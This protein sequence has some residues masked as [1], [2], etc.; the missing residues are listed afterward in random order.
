KMTWS[1]EAESLR[2]EIFDKE[3]LPA[4][5]GR[6]EN[7]G[8][9]SELVDDLAAGATRRTRFTGSIEHCD[10]ADGEFG[11]CIRDSRKNRGSLRTI[12]EA[13]RGVLYIAAGVDSASAG[14]NRRADP[15]L[16]IRGISLFRSDPRCLDQAGPIPTGNLI[17]DHVGASKSRSDYTD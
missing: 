5:G 8:I 16:G 7:R 12:G 10:S 3:L 17:A 4:T 1:L 2:Q 13:V 9:G 6:K 11:A 15:E 14:Q